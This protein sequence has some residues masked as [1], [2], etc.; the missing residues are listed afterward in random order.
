MFLLG[1]F[2]VRANKKGLYTGIAACV[3]FT[4]YAVLTSTKTGDSV[5]LDMGSLNFTQHK[6]MIGVYSHLVLFG[7]GYLASFL[8]KKQEVAQNLT[9]NGWSGKKRKSKA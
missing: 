2:S 1:L 3:V 5:M 9:Y 8:F 6:Y 7:V 4:G